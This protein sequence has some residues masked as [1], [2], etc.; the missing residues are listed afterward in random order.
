MY[1]DYQ[2]HAAIGPPFE[3][4]NSEAQQQRQAAKYDRN[5]PK[6]RHAVGNTTVR[7]S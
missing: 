5:R 6:G 7:L 3:E 2:S 1:A 4:R